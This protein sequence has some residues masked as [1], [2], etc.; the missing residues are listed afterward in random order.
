[1]NPE[2]S[3]DAI[4]DEGHRLLKTGAP[5]VAYDVLAEGLRQ[6]PSHVRLRQLLALAMARSGASRDANTLLERLAAEGHADEETLALLARTH[7]DI[8]LDSLDPAIRASHLELAFHRYEDSYRRTHGYWSGINAATMAVL[9]GRRDEARAVARQVRAQCLSL[10]RDGGPDQYWILATLGEAAL[11]LDEIGEAEDW[12][13]RAVS[14]AAGHRG[15]LVSTRR[16]ARL[17]LKH[18]GG[19]VSHFDACFDI[20]RVVVFAGHLIDRPD[21]A[22]PRFPAAREPVV[23]DAIDAAVAALRP[24]IGYAAAGCGG[25]ILFLESLARRGAETHVILPYNRD[26]FCADSVDLVPGTDW[27]AR[28]AQ[29]L[30]QASE[31]I[32]AAEHPIGGGLAYEY[33]F[34]F[35]DG[36]A[37]VKADELDTEL[38]CLALWDGKAGDGAGGTASSIEHWQRTGRRIEIIDLSALVSPPP[39]ISVQIAAATPASEHVPHPL[40][41]EIV[42]LLFADASG[43]SRLTEPEIPLFIEHFLGTVAAKIAQAPSKP[44]QANTWGDGLY[45]VFDSVAATGTFA[46]SLSEAIRDTDWRGL[47]FRNEISVRIGL[48]AGP[49]FV[50][51]DPVTARVNYLGAHVSRAARIE[52]IAPPG[53]VYASGAFAALARGEASAF[54]CAYVGQTPLAKGYGTSPTYVVRPIL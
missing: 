27:P 4:C 36:A 48:H 10:Y 8:A 52:P 7:K 1:M 44:L 41:V 5:L 6:F 22:V 18:L 32:I 33:G 54:R 30:A 39:A 12:Y 29:V 37:R 49:A 24:G 20:P 43:F 42:G 9:L 31:V 53:E 23:R 45:L 16:N 13:G 28:Y 40:E 11:V 35:L 25:D 14:V 47:G 17:L 26:E 2:S 15:D 19:D 46:L 34:R 38:V 50:C 21:R 3:V 51:T